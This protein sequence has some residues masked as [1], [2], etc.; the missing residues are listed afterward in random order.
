MT[1][2]ENDQ[3]AEQQ[4][5]AENP[6][7]SPRWVDTRKRHPHSEPTPLAFTIGDDCPSP[8][9]VLTV[10][11]WSEAAHNHLRQI[12]TALAQ[13]QPRQSLPLVSLRGRLNV[14]DQQLLRFEYDLGL[15]QRILLWTQTDVPTS[16]T[17]MNDAVLQWIINDLTTPTILAVAETAVEQLK[18]LARKK[19]A[20]ETYQRRTTPFHWGTSLSKTAKAF[21][22]TSYAELA[23]YVALHL[24]G[25]CV[26]PE[27]PGLR[28]IIGNELESNQAELMTEPLSP[29]RNTSFSLVVRIRVFSYPGRS[30][31]II[32]IEFTRRTWARELKEQ[33]G[34]RTISGYAFPHGSTHVLRFTVRK[35]KQDDGEWNYTPDRDFTPIERR[36]FA[37]Q[38]L[39]V[40]TILQ[41]GLALTQCKLLIGQKHGT[42]KRGDAHSGVPDLDKMEGFQQITKLA[43]PLGLRP[44]HGLTPI[45]TSVKTVQDYGQYWRDRTSTK[46]EKLEHYTRWLQEVQASIRA[47]YHDTHHL[48]IAVQTGFGIEADAQEAEERL[49]AILPQSLLITRI[50]L[51]QDVHGPRSQLPGS[52]LTKSAERAALRIA[53]WSSFIESVKYHE[54]RSGRKVDGIL[55]LACEW[56]PDNAHDDRIN[57]RAGRIALARGVGVPVQY[58]LP[59]EEFR[60][61]ADPKVKSGKV[62]SSEQIEAEIAQEFETRLMVAWLDLAFKSLGRVRPGKLL[63]EIHT[64]Y[65]DPTLGMV[66]DRVLALGVIRRNSTRTIANEPAFLPYAIELDIEQ[67]TCSASIA[68]EDP[69]THLLTWFDTLPLPQ[70]LVRLA[71]LGTVQLASAKKDRQKILA[72]RTQ[73]FFKNQLVDF[74]KRSLHPII[75]VDAN[76]SRSAWSWLQDKDIDPTN[77]HLAGGFN[78]QVA[79]SHA[80]LVRIRTDNSPK[81]LWDQEYSGNTSDTDETICYHA[82][83]WAEADLFKLND[84]V[85]TSVYLS[86]GSEIRTGRIKGRSSYREIWGMQQK[87]DGEK[88]RFAA[89]MMQ[90]FDHNWATPTGVEIVVVRPEHDHPDQIARL[91][92]WL[93][94]CYVHVGPWTSKP[95]PTFFATV[96]KEYLPD[97]AID[98]EESER[99]YEEVES[100][101]E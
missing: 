3:T 67:G 76:T 6:S 86:F 56:Y 58:V 98:D 30:L 43:E 60:E 10:A 54:Q 82:P 63:D 34:T 93:R 20:V 94:Q 44:W 32:A 38:K 2:P 13:A 78:A 40:A 80:R 24:E 15:N 55:V 91:I 83:R 85:N 65:A 100:G 62:K 81:V 51:P 8:V 70:A 16:R 18:Q 25:Q 59:R 52:Q 23:D 47:C 99:E 9:H 64:I 92:E 36:Y 73:E 89:T 90:R 48:V 31:P 19:A 41:E 101:E 22:S 87:K 61:E 66:P 72:E 95:A 4:T 68:Y 14:A 97:Y 28:R 35:V 57:K 74:S 79:W 75:I 39:T 5:T 11:T 26:F 7:V 49:Q 27:L 37:T 17:D 45:A 77:V 29:G 33:G 50:P 84:T 71:S 69:A 46:A 1:Q 21:H 88:K 53:G 12:A 42:G 96:L